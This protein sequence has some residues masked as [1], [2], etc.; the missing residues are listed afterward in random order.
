MTSAAA[1][2]RSRRAVWVGAAGAIVVAGGVTVGLL[3][4]GSDSAAR[5]AFSAALAAHQFV[6]A[7]NA[8]DGD[9]AAA[10]ACAD[11]AGEARSA[12]VSGTDPGIDFVLD[13]VTP[14]GADAATAEIT[15]RL[16]LAGTTQR[17]PY[18]VHLARTEGRWLVCGQL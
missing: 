18:L 1:A 2:L 15:Q 11:F 6:A 12:A 13:S 5:G 16:Q 4:A 17:Q 8:G 3:V 9:S 14:E 7:L 10:V